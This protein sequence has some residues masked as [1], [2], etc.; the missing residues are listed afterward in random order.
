V[1]ASLPTETE[2]LLERAALDAL[3]IA[4]KAGSVVTGFAKV[5]AALHGSDVAG[6]L[7]AADAAGDGKRK[8]NGALQRKTPQN[9]RE[10]P[11]IEIFSG[12]QLDLA[13]SR[14]NVVHAA[15]LDGTTSETFLARVKRLQRFR[16]SPATAPADG[17]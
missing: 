14:P 12:E 3:A 8:L 7:H 4:G 5:E 9:P 11:I 10:M 6:L 16:N 1:P 17:A 15:L 13:L 2:R